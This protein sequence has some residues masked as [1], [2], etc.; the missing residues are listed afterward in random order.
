MLHDTF[1]RR[2]L[3]LALFSPTS[4]QADNAT[5]AMAVESLPWARNILTSRGWRTIGIIGFTLLLIIPLYQLSDRTSAGYYK[6]YI[7]NHVS[8][9]F[10]DTG[11]YN[12]TLYQDG[13]QATVHPTWNFSTPCEGFPNTDN[14]LLV[15]KTGATEAFD[16][17]PT[18]L[19][20]SMQCLPDFL[21]FSDLVRPP[22][23]SP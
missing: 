22:S 2:A 12:N 17:L 19:L 1:V 23:C 16:K 4:Q 8:S 21:L 10:D 13:N 6:D 18:Q 3:A 7:S 5:A 9:F 15:M 20:T 14:I 11:V